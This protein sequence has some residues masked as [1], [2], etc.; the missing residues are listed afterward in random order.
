MR[1]VSLSF[2]IN[3]NQIFPLL[4]C[5][6]IIY[7]SILLCMGH[8]KMMKIASKILNTNILFANGMNNY[9]EQKSIFTICAKT[10]LKYLTLCDVVKCRKYAEECQKIVSEIFLTYEINEGNFGVEG[11][12]EN[13][14][15]LRLK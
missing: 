4:D 2:H 1:Q 7:R 14:Y 3:G 10:E 6:F 9:L 5:K 15:C 12:Y 11:L 8:T 13:I